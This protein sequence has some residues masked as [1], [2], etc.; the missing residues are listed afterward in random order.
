[1]K[2][3]GVEERIKLVFKRLPK[4]IYYVDLLQFWAPRRIADGSF[5]TTSDQT[6]AL[7]K[8]D[9]QAEIK[10]MFEAISATHPLHFARALIPSQGDYCLSNS[11]LRCFKQEAYCLRQKD[12]TGIYDYPLTH[13]AKRCGF[14]FC[15]AICVQNTQF[16]DKICVL[17]L[18]LLPGDYSSEYT[19]GLSDSLLMSVKQHLNNNFKI[20]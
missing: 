10:N 19:G 7:G 20:L 4:I 8:S 17:E 15:V 18:F 12:F 6:F 9:S 13:Y 14:S 16:V 1:M 11:G 2:H 3:H 5:L